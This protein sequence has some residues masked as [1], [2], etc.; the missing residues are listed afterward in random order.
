MWEYPLSKQVPDGEKPW[1]DR[2]PAL[3]RESGGIYPSPLISCCT[4]RCI[5]PWAAVFPLIFHSIQ[6][7]IPQASQPLITRLYQLWLVLAGT[8][9][10]NMVACICILASGAS[11]GGSDLG[12]S[13]GYALPVNTCAATL[14]GERDG[15]SYLIF[16]TPLSFLL[17]YR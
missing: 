6:D 9:I 15:R 3:S 1:R 7:E 12:S 13:I 8:L 5:A 14:T 4:C 16:I 11:N 2:R 17:W 10:I